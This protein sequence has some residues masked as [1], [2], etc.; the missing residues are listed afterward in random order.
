MSE[1]MNMVEVQEVISETMNSGIRANATGTQA[2]K[3]TPSDLGWDLYDVRANEDPT[4]FE[5]NAAVYE[6]DGEEGD[7]G[8]EFPAL[9][10]QLFGTPESRLEI[11]GIDYSM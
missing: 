4:G 3:P 10:L 6:W 5:C 7:V 9:E 1:N 2:G 11:K 8:P